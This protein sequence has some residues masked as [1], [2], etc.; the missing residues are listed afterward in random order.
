MKLKIATC[1]ICAVILAIPAYGLE[2]RRIHHENILFVEPGDSYMALFGSDWM[3]VF[4]ANSRITF[5]DSQGR[6]THS[7]DKLVVGARLV[8]P[9][10]TYLTE[11]A[12]ERLSRY[13]KIKT[14]ALETIREAETFVK[15]QPPRSAEVY[16]QA[17]HLLEK[18][19]EASNGL[20]FGFENYIEAERLAQES[21]RGFTIDR[22]LHKANLGLKQ[23]RE[24]MESERLESKNRLKILY[25]KLF[26]PLV[27][28]TALLSSLLWFMR[29]GKQKERLLRVEQWLNK[30]SERI[31]LMEKASV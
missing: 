16:L 2:K 19:R 1:V 22:K 13:E 9:T 25:W 23:L 26:T 14:A 18:A 4:Q 15:Q 5:Y 12:M 30:Q 11:R 3:K 21:I 17:L 28:L 31:E 10:G 27:L 29:R 7:P 24:G 20:T 6:L 8:L